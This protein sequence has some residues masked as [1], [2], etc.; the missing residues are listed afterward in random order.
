MVDY[1]R[2]VIL[3]YDAELSPPIFFVPV[4]TRMYEYI[5]PSLIEFIS[6]FS[7]YLL[8]CLLQYM[9]N[10]IEGVREKLR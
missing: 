5:V 6:L 1:L 8:V 7:K 3:A 2:N 9:P 10:N 4:S